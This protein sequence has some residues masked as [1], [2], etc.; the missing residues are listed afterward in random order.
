MTGYL[1]R[2]FVAYPDSRWGGCFCRSCGTCARVVCRCAS[3]G[4]AT[5]GDGFLRGRAS[6]A[7][8]EHPASDLATYLAG[9]RF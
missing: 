7:T 4:W 1:Q 8:A 2:R 6:R 9:G 3:F 5:D